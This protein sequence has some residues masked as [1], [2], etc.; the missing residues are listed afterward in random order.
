MWTSNTDM[1]IETRVIGSLPSPSSPA[2]SG[3]GG[4]AAIIVT[5]PSAGAVTSPSPLGVVRIGSRKEAATQSVTPARIQPSQSQPTT[6]QKNKAI[7]AAITT[8]LRPSGWTA[9]IR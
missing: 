8:N 7:A 6:T 2:S 4:T 5:M 9:G 1:K 3:G